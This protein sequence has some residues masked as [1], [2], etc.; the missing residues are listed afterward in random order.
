MDV[1]SNEKFFDCAAEYYDSMVDFEKGLERR[2]KALSNFI[3]PGMKTAADLGCGTGLDS[4]SLSMSGISVTGFDIS[5][6]M[7]TQAR[8]NTK[9]FA[10]AAKFCKYSIDKIPTKFNNRFDFITSLGNTLANLNEKQLA[11]ALSRIY[12]MLKPGGSALIHILN[13]DLILKSGER[14]VKISRNDN[15]HIIRFYDFIE[16][17][18]NF[19]ILKYSTSDINNHEL[20]TTKIYP[21]KPEF[22]KKH[23]QNA[24]FEKIKYFENFMKAPFNKRSSKDLVIRVSK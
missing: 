10:A 7:I 3:E 2:I 16:D 12:K 21:H 19:N 23:L 5:Q 9:R 4:I 11:G 18:L 6:K 17:H 15:Y 8:K 13:Y 24:G 20:I 22:L 14:I 1:I